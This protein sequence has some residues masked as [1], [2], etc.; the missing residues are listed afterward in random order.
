MHK[1][2]MRLVDSFPTQFTKR[3]FHS[4]LRTTEKLQKVLTEVIVGREGKVVRQ[5]IESR[6]ERS[7]GYRSFAQVSRSINIHN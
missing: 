7:K 4:R 5:G 6:V 1:T 3:L 2:W